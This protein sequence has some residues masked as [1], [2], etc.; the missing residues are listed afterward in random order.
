M[1]ATR[2]RGL[3]LSYVGL[4]ERVRADHPPRVIR[5]VVNSVLVTLSAEFDALYFLYGRASIPGYAI[6][7]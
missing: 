7:A 5:E 4:E 1:A 2:L 3:L 6:H